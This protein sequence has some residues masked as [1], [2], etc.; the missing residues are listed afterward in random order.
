LSYLS[1]AQRMV[2][3]WSVEM[4]VAAVVAVAVAVAVL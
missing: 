3:R 1:K 4:A 2:G